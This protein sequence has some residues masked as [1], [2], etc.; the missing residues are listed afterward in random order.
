M[1][2]V[3]ERQMR[4]FGMDETWEMKYTNSDVDLLHELMEMEE[5]GETYV[6]VSWAPSMQTSWFTSREMTARPVNFPYNPSGTQRDPCVIEGSCN[7]NKN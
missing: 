3:K 4:Y 6:Y 2:E 1:N 5:R 7:L